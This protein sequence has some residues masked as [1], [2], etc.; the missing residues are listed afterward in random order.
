MQIHRENGNL[1]P[2]I[3]REGHRSGGTQIRRNKIR[4]ENPDRFDANGDEASLGFFSDPSLIS[5]FYNRDPSLDLGKMFSSKLVINSSIFRFKLNKNVSTNYKWMSTS[6]HEVGKLQKPLDAR[7]TT[8]SYKTGEPQH[9]AILL[10]MST[11]R[12]N[13]KEIVKFG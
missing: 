3:N 2:G 13:V 10:A 4:K 7:D 11:T 1:K 9:E 6:L 8:V 5:F 12:R